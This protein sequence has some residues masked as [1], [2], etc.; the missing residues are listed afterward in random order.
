MEQLERVIGSSGVFARSLN[1]TIGYERVA[2]IKRPMGVITDPGMCFGG[3]A[4]SE[5]ECRG[6]AAGCNS[7]SYDP[8]TY[9]CRKCGC[10]TEFDITASDPCRNDEVV[11]EPEFMSMHSYSRDG[12]SSCHS[13][14]T[15]KCPSKTCSKLLPTEDCPLVF[16]T[17]PASSVTADDPRNYNGRTIYCEYPRSEIAKS[18]AAVT[19]YTTMYRK[20]FGN[21]HYFDHELMTAMCGYPA[22]PSKC[23][24][25][26]RQYKPDGTV[27]C[28]NMIACPMCRE[29]AKSEQGKD[30][31]DGLMREW[32]TEHT[33]PEAY[34]DNTRTDPAC[35]CINGVMTSDYQIIAAAA[36]SENPGCWYTPCKDPEIMKNLVPREYREPK[37]PCPT[38]C[39]INWNIIDS[40]DIDIDDVTQYIEGC[41]IVK[42]DPDPK[43]EPDPKPKPEPEEEINIAKWLAENKKSILIGGGAI[44]LIAGIALITKK[45]TKQ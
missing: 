24:A 8:G 32:C 31:A 21:E 4:E 42:P 35:R 25:T 34:E 45:L 30:T 22:D 17:V 40:S 38:S 39:T 26:S 43:P 13:K 12:S 33:D 9:S 14:N 10:M 18:C 2:T 28:A 5:D 7:Y 1:D 20:Q 27:T 29:W 41:N 6:F 16:G 44:V 11:W 37:N 23:P 19:D 15:A 36:N 3:T